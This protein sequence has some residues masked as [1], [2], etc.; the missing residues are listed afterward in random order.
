MVCMAHLTLQLRYN[1]RRDSPGLRQLAGSQA[2]GAHARV[3]AAA[4]A[5]ANR[6]QVVRGLPW[7]PWI[8]THGNLCAETGAAH[9]NRIR[10]IRKQV[11]R[12]EL[13]VALHIA[14]VEI[15]EHHPAVFAGTVA[16]DLD[17]SE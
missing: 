1:F 4:V 6:R 8:R 9:R 16:D 2:D 13:V 11:I 3:S 15:E 17:R 7:G 12:N 5:F 14:P 10:G